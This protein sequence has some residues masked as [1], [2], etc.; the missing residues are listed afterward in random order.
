M[1]RLQ[2]GLAIDPAFPF[3]LHQLSFQLSIAHF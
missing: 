2:A 1:Q 3:A